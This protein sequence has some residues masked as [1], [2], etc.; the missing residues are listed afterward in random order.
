MTG[1]WRCEGPE[2]VR[3]AQH[4]AGADVVQI[5]D[6]ITLSDL[7][8]I[9][10]VA[11]RDAIQILPPRNGVVS[12]AAAT[13]RSRLPTPTW[14]ASR[15]SVAIGDSQ[16]LARINTIGVCKTIV[17]GDSPGRYTIMPREAEEGISVPDC[18]I[19][20]AALIRFGVNDGD[21]CCG[22]DQNKPQNDEYP[23]HKAP[24]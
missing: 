10:A 18:V 11:E 1:Q 6:A 5:V 21:D 24:P 2:S 13:A 17:R 9:H 20:H 4:V 15:T 16:D 12:G 19:D 7:P 8:H 3:N 14:L 22:Q 23:A